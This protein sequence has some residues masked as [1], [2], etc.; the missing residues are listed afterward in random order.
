MG[1]SVFY[2]G[3]LRDKQFIPALVTEVSDLCDSLHWEYHHIHWRKDYPFEGICFCPPD[4]EYIWLAFLDDG[5]LCN[6]EMY[7]WLSNPPSQP[8]PD[9]EHIALDA[10]VQWAGPEAHMIMI[11]LLRYIANR[12]FDSFEMVDESEYW[13]TRDPDKCR[14][15]FTMFGHWMD[16]MS[17]DLGKL[18]GRGHERGRSYRDR[19][20]E[21]M[22]E[23]KSMDD[24]LKVMGNPYR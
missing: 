13:E 24:I 20:E 11:N 2:S 16:N 1:L 6:P 10:I 9:D 19:L 7:H 14:D 23:G 8:H 5:K 4:S 22:R 21:L 18:D 17:E 3:T 12:Y 15:W